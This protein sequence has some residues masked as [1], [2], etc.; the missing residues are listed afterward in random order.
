MLELAHQG[1]QVMQTR[2]VEL[3]WVND[4]VIEV[5]SSFEDAPGTLI[6]EDPLVE[7]RNK[8]RGLAHDRNVAKL[9]LVEVPDRPGVARSV[10]EPLAEAGINVDMIVQ[11]IGHG[12]ATD[13]SFTIPQVELAKAKRILEPVARD[14]GSR[15]L[16]TDSSVAKVSIVGAGIQ[17]APGYAAR[18]FRALSDAGVNIEMIS[19][20]E[21]RITTIIAED[22]LET[23]VR[24]LH[25]AFELERPEA[26]EAAAAG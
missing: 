3:G 13:L 15:E 25:E 21:I 23:A 17:N 6:K 5:L 4:V 16:T 10:F 2:A 8:V 19:T 9:T 7:Q 14:L 18:M 22:A 26:I 24:A 1:A 12:G 20:S 11:N